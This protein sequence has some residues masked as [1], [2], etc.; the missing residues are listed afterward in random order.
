[1]GTVLSDVD[2]EGLSLRDWVESVAGLVYDDVSDDTR[3]IVR[4]PSTRMLSPCKSCVVDGDSG[5]STDVNASIPTTASSNMVL[6]SALT[7]EIHVSSVNLICER[8]MLEGDYAM[9][10]ECL[11]LLS[12]P[13]DSR[14]RKILDQTEAELS[15]KRNELMR[16]WTEYGTHRSMSKTTILQ[17]QLIENGRMSVMW[18]KAGK[19]GHVPITD[20]RRAFGEMIELVDV[21]G[22]NEEIF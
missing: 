20:G 10:N 18:A 19:G 17:S 3:P 5:A 8:F 1:M 22:P 14:T 16:R 4:L 2:R 15:K 6:E 12:C 7:R 21:A 11:T 13:G 9:A